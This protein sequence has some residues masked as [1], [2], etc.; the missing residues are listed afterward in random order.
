MTFTLNFQKLQIPRALIGQ[1]EQQKAQSLEARLTIHGGRLGGKLDDF[2][3][4]ET[5]TI[6]IPKISLFIQ[7]D[8]P[9]YKPGQTG[10]K[11]SHLHSFMDGSLKTEA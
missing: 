2:N 3:S 6:T 10:N 1:I 5:I 4:S 7:I 8:K 11:T 9:I